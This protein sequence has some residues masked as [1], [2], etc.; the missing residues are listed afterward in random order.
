MEPLNQVLG[1]VATWTQPCL[2]LVGNHDQVDLGGS[3]H[4]LFPLQCAR[5]DLIHIFDSPGFFRGALWLPYRRDKALIQD[6][7]NAASTN[8]DLQL[9]AIMAHADVQTAKFNYAI[10]AREGVPIDL[11]PSQLPV[12]SGHYHIPHTVPNSSITYIGSCFQVTA[13]E[14]GEQKR[15]VVFDA[16]DGWSIK[17]EIPISIGPRFIRVASLEELESPV[18]DQD[19]R[20]GDRIKIIL[21]E[22]SDRIE[23]G[24]D[25]DR[26]SDSRLQ[27]ARSG[28]EARGIKVEVSRQ[29]RSAELPRITQAEDKGPDELL[30]EYAKRARM[31]EPALEVAKK[32]LGEELVKGGRAG[33]GNASRSVRLEFGMLE[34]E[35]YG[36]FKEVQKYNLSSRSANS[37]YAN[38]IY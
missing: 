33:G 6:A 26:L 24:L 9:K 31:S 19:L 16:E 36:P 11:F 7:V 14:A 29:S 21:S 4:S 30:V 5:P 18:L 38:D 3:R 1:L 15:F 25:Q 20:A 35:G 22:P 23:Q 2:F 12:Y 28:L 17:E 34:L 10:Q 13:A 37:T 8:P 32:A 27:V